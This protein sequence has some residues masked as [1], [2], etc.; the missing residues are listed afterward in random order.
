MG[1]GRPSRAAIS[2]CRRPVSAW[3]VTICR[4]SS[5]RAEHG[6]QHQTVLVR[7][8]GVIGNADLPVLLDQ[9]LRPPVLPQAADGQIPGDGQ[10]PGHR[11]ALPAVSAGSVPH[12]QT[13]VVE[14]I[15]CVVGVFDD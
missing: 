2:R 5:L 6:L 14:N 8:G 7:D 11:L 9:G 1:S 12:L 15:L 13:G 10:H 3:R 4:S